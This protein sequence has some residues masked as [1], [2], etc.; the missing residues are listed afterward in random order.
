MSWL[1]KSNMNKVAVIILN[2]RIKELIL[3]CIESVKKSTYKN[4]DIIIVDN[5]PEEGLGELVDNNIQ[6]LPNRNTGYTGGNNLGIKKALE[7]SP[8]FI[9][10]LNPDTI[11]DKDAIKYLVETLEDENAGIVGPKILFSDKKTIWYAGGIFDTANV[12]GKHKGVDELDN[13]KYEKLEE[14]DYVTGAAMFVSKE[15][16]QKIGFFDEKYFLYYEDSDFS[17]RAKE[18][19]FK[20][21]YQPK[22]MVYHENAQSTGLGSPLQDYFITR[23]RMLY[24][25]KFLPFRTRFALF[26]EALKNLGNPIRRLALWDFLMGNFGKGSF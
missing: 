23:N 7:S 13:E 24:A 26:R 3:K 2:Y 14:T 17:K 25:S 12:I 21:L 19:G 20:V 16:F 6:Y 9:F 10:I 5:S 1:E 11:I 18:A 4:L 15:V 22:A 8:D